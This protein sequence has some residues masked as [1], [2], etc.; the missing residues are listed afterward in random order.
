MTVGSVI[1]AK[2]GIQSRNDKSKSN[3]YKLSPYLLPTLRCYNESMNSQ[4]NIKKLAI[5]EY[6]TVSE[7]AYILGVTPLTLRNWDNEGKLRARR[8][9]INNYRVYKRSDVEFFLRRM[10]GGVNSGDVI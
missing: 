10:G 6:F 5:K 9:P 7:A 4:K 8:N 1:P 3:T 2:A